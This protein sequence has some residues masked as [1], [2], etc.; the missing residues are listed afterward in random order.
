MSD[1][2]I[3]VEVYKTEDG[4]NCLVLASVYK[5]NCSQETTVIVEDDVLEVFEAARRESERQRSRERRHGLKKIY[6]GN[7][8]YEAKLGMVTQAPDEEIHS[9]MYLEYLKQF[10]DDKVY[11]RGMMYYLHKFT[12]AEIAELEGVSQAAV[13]KSIRAFK[14]VMA[15][16]QCSRPLQRRITENFSNG[17]K[18]WT[19]LLRRYR[20]TAKKIPFPFSSM[21][22][23]RK[24]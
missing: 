10:F 14:E 5:N 7:E 4:K 23:I 8:D 6:L 2:E 20:N 18:K 9:D 3:K 1:E 16:S 21:K 11:K 19:F 22:R 17:R 13:S 12:E 24:R 15:K